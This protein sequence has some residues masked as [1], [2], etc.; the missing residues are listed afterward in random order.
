MQSKS[1]KARKPQA[2]IAM[3]TIQVRP[4]FPPAK[5]RL[6]GSDF[7]P[8]LH[9]QQELCA[10]FVGGHELIRLHIAV[11]NPDIM[12]GCERIGELLGQSY[13]TKDF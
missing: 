5:F 8:V 2:C 12:S 6:L 1:Q 11:N 4:A 7:P 10:S 9:R 13:H 3:F